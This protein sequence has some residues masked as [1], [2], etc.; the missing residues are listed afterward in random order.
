VRRA[1]KFV[2][3]VGDSHLQHTAIH[4]TAVAE[5][6][7][8][9]CSAPCSRAGR[10][11][12]NESAA[13]IFPRRG[14]IEWFSQESV[15]LAD[16]TTALFVGGGRVYRIGHPM[17]GGDDCT[18]LRIAPE[19][20]SDALPLAS[21]S[22]RAV[23]LSARA[24]RRVQ[25]SI[26]RLRALRGDALA[27]DESAV[28]LL[29]TVCAELGVTE[30]PQRNAEDVSDVRRLIASKPEQNLALSEVARAV[31]VSPYHLARRFRNVTGTS[32]HQYRT[33]LR[34][35][36]AVERIR[37]GWTDLATLALDLGFAHHSHFSFAFRKAYGIRPS[38]LLKSL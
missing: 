20:L 23:S 34:L 25:L 16:S 36:L 17:P 12:H 7:D 5:V 6:T 13:F 10:E 35:A 31:H 14:L 2:L 33:R 8:V 37:Q 26:L 29:E 27:G 9:R 19:I 24:E 28:A 15:A 32:I 22:F 21:H 38:E 3:F 30:R 18:T 11:E 1:V 4:R